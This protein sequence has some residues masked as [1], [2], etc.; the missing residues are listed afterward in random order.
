[1]LK[2]EESRTATSCVGTEG[3]C[4]IPKYNAILN[5]VAAYVARDS[6]ENLGNG[7]ERNTSIHYLPKLCYGG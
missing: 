2:S 5:G 1:M 4:P 7:S 3:Q 6:G